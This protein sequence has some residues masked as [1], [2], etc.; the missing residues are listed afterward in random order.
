MIH[1]D[2]MDTS[3]LHGR[4]LCA[5]AAINVWALQSHT[6][7]TNAVSIGHVAFQPGQVYRYIGTF[8]AG[9]E[10]SPTD[11]LKLLSSMTLRG[12]FLDDNGR[13]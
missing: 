9:N 3:H 10:P 12:F 6:A 5:H 13:F 11:S 2:H 4:R 8:T 7:H 1:T